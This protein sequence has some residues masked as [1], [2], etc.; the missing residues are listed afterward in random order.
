MRTIRS[1][2][3]VD[4]ENIFISLKNEH[5]LAAARR[6]ASSPD[7]WIEWISS[8]L[9]HTFES[10]ESFQRRII[11]RRCYL[12]SGIYSNYRPYLVRAGFNVI[13]CPSLTS[14]GKNST[15]IHMVLDMVED[16]SNRPKFHEFIIMSGD[17]DFTPLLFRIRSKNRRVVIISPSFAA[18]SYRSVADLSVDG[19]RFLDEVIQYS[20]P[21]TQA[22]PTTPDHEPNDRQTSEVN[23]EDVDEYVRREVSASDVPVK[24]ESLALGIR[25]EFHNA[26]WFGHT[27]FSQFLDSRMSN[28]DL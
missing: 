23:L 5:G 14:L 12:N 15:D 8:E 7:R 24:M 6:F 16:L 27:T 20:S 11:Q 4:F 1:A 13:D 22:I 21:A 17:A 3:Y 25:Q 19:E 2:L 9:P 26:D 28:L 10:D 18:Q